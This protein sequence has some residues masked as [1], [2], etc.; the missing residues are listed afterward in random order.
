MSLTGKDLHQKFWG[1]KTD[2]WKPEEG[3][4]AKRW[5]DLA[6]FVNLQVAT[7]AQVAVEASSVSIRVTERSVYNA[8]KNLVVHTYGLT[9]EG[10]MAEVMKV[11]KPQ[12]VVREWMNGQNVREFVGRI[13][14][15]VVQSTAAAIIREEARAVMNGKLK[16]TVG[17]G[18]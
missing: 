8:V 1:W 9:R 6:A 12:D 17:D 13:A 10:I 2:E 5:D 18:S 16:I 4:D 7:A 14:R 3:S 15:E 11:V